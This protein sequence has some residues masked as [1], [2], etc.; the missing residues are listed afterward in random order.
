MCALRSK[1]TM[2]SIWFHG[3]RTTIFTHLPLI[4]NKVHISLA[5]IENSIGKLPQGCTYAIGV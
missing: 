2:V 4:D 5:A 1:M 3:K